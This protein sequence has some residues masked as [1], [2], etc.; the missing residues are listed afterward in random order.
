MKKRLKPLMFIT[1]IICLL[2]SQCTYGAEKDLSG[3]IQTT[4]Q[5]LQQSFGSKERN[6]LFDEEILPAGSSTSDWIAMVL[7]FS[8][9][10]DAYAEYL[11]NL[12]AY[13]VEQYKEQGYLDDVKATEYHRIVLTMLALGGEPTQ[14]Q[15][16]DKKIDLVADGTWNFYGG[17]P[18]EQGTN[19]LIYALLTLDAKAYQTEKEEFRQSLINEILEVQDEEGGF[20]LSASFGADIDIT[21]MALQ[22][23]APYQEQTTVKEAT[24]KA[25]NWLSGKL[26]ENATYIAHDSETVE[27]IAQTILAL[28]ALGIDPAEDERFIKEGQT[29]LDSMNRFRLEDGTYKHEINDEVSNTVATYQS[30]L[31]LEAAWKLRTDGTWIFDFSEYQLPESAE[32][33]GSD[34]TIFVLGGGVTVLVVGAAIVFTKRNKQKA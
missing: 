23:L 10:K 15:A 17:S 9:E 29:L 27:S 4:A 34:T 1:L 6:L 19:G 30:L 21:A 22:A 26:S 25:L 11:E 12:E 8:G 16:V 7:A 31:A 28:C 5:S 33:S 13:V 14:I 32:N 24:D 2:F 18:G 3:M 20:R